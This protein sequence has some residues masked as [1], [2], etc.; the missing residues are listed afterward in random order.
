MSYFNASN[1]PFALNNGRAY[2]QWR[3]WKLN[4]AARH[5]DELIVPVHDPRNLSDTEVMALLSTIR[6]NNMVI[7]ASRSCQDSDKSIPRKIAAR[8]G[9]RNLNH[10]WLADD[11]GLTSLTVNDAGSH[12]FYIPYTNRPINWHTDG[13]YNPAD[14]QVCGLMLHCVHRAA[15][16]GENALLDHEIA[17]ILLRDE[18]PAYIEA[19]MSQ[20]AMTIPPGTDMHGNLRDAAVGPVFSVIA[21]SG[22]LHMRYT[23]RQ[24]NIIWK[25]DETVK[26]AI[27]FLEA[28]LDS[29]LPCIHRATLE[30]GMGLISNNVLHD[31]SGFSDMVGLPQRLLYRA[32]YFDRI[33]RS[34]I[35]SIDEE[36]LEDETRSER[37]RH[38]SGYSSPIASTN[39]SP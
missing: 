22:D 16:G 39:S 30:P 29:D 9:L 23:M 33:T 15:H 38:F 27:G 26:E 12:P 36:E 17:Y 20:D 35:E 13:Y 6:H 25:D 37:S 14:A 34:G 21:E 1:T 18:N 28:I 10:N 32:R 7:Y 5:V 2:Q 19:L 8:F 4:H 3:R 31:R 11:D 24:R